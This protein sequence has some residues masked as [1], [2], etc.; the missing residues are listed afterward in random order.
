MSVHLPACG[1]AGAADAVGAARL[2]RSTHRYFLSTSSS[3]MKSSANSLHGLTS[4]G[5]TMSQ[6]AGGTSVLFFFT[7]PQLSMSKSAVVKQLVPLHPSKL[8]TTSTVRRPT[9]SCARAASTRHAESTRGRSMSTE[10]GAS[11]GRVAVEGKV[12]GEPPCA[13]PTEDELCVRRLA[14]RTLQLAPAPLF[15]CPSLKFFWCAGS[16]TS[17]AKKRTPAYRQGPTGFGIAV[18]PMEHGLLK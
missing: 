1:Q 11:R 10:R 12:R 18:L 14:A 8:P 16:H 2:V 7:S 6:V 13:L 17:A 4:S 5:C 9:L 15:F 3:A